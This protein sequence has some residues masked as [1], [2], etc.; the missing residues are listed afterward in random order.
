MNTYHSSTVFE[1]KQII[2]I[3]TQK[4]TKTKTFSIIFSMFLYKPL[5]TQKEKKKKL[6][7]ADVQRLVL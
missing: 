6:N 3:Y 4:Q 2:N 5:T 1:Q 7:M